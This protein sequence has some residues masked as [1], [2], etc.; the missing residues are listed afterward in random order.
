M[1]DNCKKVTT[2][3]SAISYIEL[4]GNNYEHHFVITCHTNNMESAKK[5]ID[6][7]IDK[8]IEKQKV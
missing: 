6:F 4:K 8:E 5:T 7:L 2:P 1:D 3:F